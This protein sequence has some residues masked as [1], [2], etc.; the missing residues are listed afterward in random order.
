MARLAGRRMTTA[1]CF[2]KLD[3]DFEVQE[4]LSPKTPS[5]LRSGVRKLSLAQRLVSERFVS[6]ETDTASPKGAQEDDVSREPDT[7]RTTGRHDPW[8]QGPVSP[9]L[10]ER[11]PVSPRSSND[12]WKLA[13]VSPRSGVESLPLSPR[14]VRSTKAVAAAPVSITKSNISEQS[15][16]A[17][18]TS[19]LLPPLA[20]ASFTRRAL[21]RRTEPPLRRPS[22]AGQNLPS[23]LMTPRTPKGVK[24]AST[25][26]DEQ[27]D[28]AIKNIVPMVT[29]K[30]PGHAFSN[31]DQGTDS[32]ELGA[33][34]MH[35]SFAQS[36]LDAQEEADSKKT[37]SVLAARRRHTLSTMAVQT[38][39]VDEKITTVQEKIDRLRELQVASE[40]PKEL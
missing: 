20:D 3:R 6:H 39:Q 8:K 14:S 1:L 7:A 13:P 26:L 11:P 15:T 21:R 19:P 40:L 30:L 9:R 18:P 38:C 24:F 22:F 10:Q 36:I 31:T 32:L 33:R 35:A 27:F 17:S 12:P 4:P 2:E 37:T 16:E 28:E 29:V 34:P 23:E 25:D 5:S